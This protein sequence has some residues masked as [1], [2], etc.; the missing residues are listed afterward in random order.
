MPRMRVGAALLLVGSTALAAPI[1]PTTA[2]PSFSFEWHAPRA[3]PSEADVVAR[4]ERLIGRALL[5][6]SGAQPVALVARVQA[7]GG[8]WQLD[9][10]SPNVQTRTVLASSC[11]ELGDAAAL[12]VALAIDPHFAGSPQSASSEP[13]PA[14]PP[15]APPIALHSDP[16]LPLPLPAEQPALMPRQQR[17]SDLATTPR[18]APSMPWAVAALGATWFGRLPGVAPGGMIQGALWLEHWII[19][20]ALGFFPA[21]HVTKDGRGGDL[22][23]GTAEADLGY[24]VFGRALAPFVGVELDRMHGV[25]TN[26]QNPSSGEAWELG[27]HAGLRCSYRLRGPI[28]LLAQ[29]RLS[30]LAT[31]PSFVLDPVGELYRPSQVGGSIG[32]GAEFRVD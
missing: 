6:E 27:F 28:W 14:S 25:G 31:R 15:S 4:A 10:Q 9:L 17:Q 16:A 11:D 7:L 29:G 26:V 12:W 2:S 32:L 18:S 5:P 1:G 13:P 30:L 21:Q 23:M 8:A 19:T 3:C 24:Q 20:P 22:W